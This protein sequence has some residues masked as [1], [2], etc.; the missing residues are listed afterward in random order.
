MGKISLTARERKSLA[1]NNSL[2]S[3]L[4]SVK[5]QPKAT[6]WNQYGEALHNLPAD[7]RSILHYQS[8]GLSLQRPSR[9]KKIPAERVA[10]GVAD[11]DGVTREGGAVVQGPMATYYTREG[12][13]VPNLA[14]DPESMSKY[15]ELGFTLDPP[16]QATPATS[17][18]TPINKPRR[19]RKA[20]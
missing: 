10:V 20:S 17:R 7:G 3:P 16:R 2:V 15:L 6:Y 12:T 8:R 11:W 5:S 14:A 1:A 13:P 4:A 18:P 19:E 9:P